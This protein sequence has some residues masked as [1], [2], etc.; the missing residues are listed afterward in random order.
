[1]LAVVVILLKF[2]NQPFTGLPRRLRYAQWFNER[3]RNPNFLESIIIGDEAGFA[4]I[5]EVNSYNVRKYGQK[6]QP[7]AFNFERRNSRGKL[8]IWAALCGDGVVLGL[9]YLR[10]LNAFAFPQFAIHL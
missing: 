6:G 8:T 1:M 7:P 10:M 5:E 4:M 2:Q 9:A 3:C